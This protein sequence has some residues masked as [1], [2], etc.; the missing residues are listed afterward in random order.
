MHEIIPHSFLPWF[1]AMPFRTT[2]EQMLTE[3]I[4]GTAETRYAKNKELSAVSAISAPKTTRHRTVKSAAHNNGLGWPGSSYSYFLL[5]SSCRGAKDLKCPAF[6]TSDFRPQTSDLVISV[7]GRRSEVEVW[8]RNGRFEVMA[9]CRLW[10]PAAPYRSWL[11]LQFPGAYSRSRS[12][13]FQNQ[14]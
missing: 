4:A 9:Q 1:E 12:G 14:L 5:M 8:D 3:F 13:I 7:R 10:P 2:Y 6:I 11:L